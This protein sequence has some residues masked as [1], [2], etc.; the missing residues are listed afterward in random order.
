MLLAGTFER[1]DRVLLFA[2]EL[3]RCCCLDD[4][5]WRDGFWVL[6]PAATTE[7]MEGCRC[8]MTAAMVPPAALGGWSRRTCGGE[9]IGAIVVVVVV[10]VVAG[11]GFCST[12]VREQRQEKAATTLTEKARQERGSWTGSGLPRVGD[13]EGS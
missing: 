11:D 6:L 13:D 5:A 4:D 12:P 2:V 3:V 7:E 8:W 10:D 9:A 1:G